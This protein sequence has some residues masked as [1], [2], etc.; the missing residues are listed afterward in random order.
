M[1]T[2]MKDDPNTARIDEAIERLVR[3][4]MGAGR[5]VVVRIDDGMSRRGLLYRTREPFAPI[6]REL[7]TPGGKTFTIQVSCVDDYALVTWAASK[8]EPK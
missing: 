7:K 2:G 1:E 8:E 4:R 6:V 3:K 5:A